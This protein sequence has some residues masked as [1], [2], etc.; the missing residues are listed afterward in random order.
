MAASKQQISAVSA[1]L[2]KVKSVDFFRPVFESVDGDRAVAHDALWSLVRTGKFPLA[3]NWALIG[4]IEA[5]A[6]PIAWA[7]LVTLLRALPPELADP[8]GAKN[9]FGCSLLGNPTRKRPDVP[10]GLAT[11][12]LR[13]A[14]SDRGAAE[15]FDGEGLTELGQ[16]AVEYGK[17]SAGLPLAA[18]SKARVLQ[19][20]ARV[21][22]TD[23]LAPEA[24]LLDP[25]TP[26]EPALVQLY[27]NEETFRSCDTY[28]LAAPFG[29]RD[30][31][32]RAIADALVEEAKRKETDRWGF[33][34][35]PYL[36]CAEPGLHLLSP[37]DLALVL[38]IAQGPMEH[39]PWAAIAKAAVGRLS[40]DERARALA[41]LETTGGNF[42]DDATREL[43]RG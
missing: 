34:G 30:E 10:R 33:R 22:V 2:K 41:A 35:I 37:E 39:R 32:E 18:G 40:A 20:L 4:V 7:D 38:G 11:L 5:S 6:G 19:G 8:G 3:K 25:S 16:L 9:G 17:G 43:L 42:N 14:W 31:W 13:A 21:L 1:A 29:S 12:A 26:R 27:C 23:G 36:E 15:S 24:Y 28:A